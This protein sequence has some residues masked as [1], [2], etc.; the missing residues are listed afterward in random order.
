MASIKI[1]A[2]DYNRKLLALPADQRDDVAG[3]SPGFVAA[4][5]GVTRQA[6]YDAMKRDRLSAFRI[7]RDDRCVAII[8]PESSVRAYETSE[9]RA[10]FTPKEYR[11]TA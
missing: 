6:V 10:K 7:Y 9:T 4:R 11:A 8:I 5:L 1:T 2:D 3:W